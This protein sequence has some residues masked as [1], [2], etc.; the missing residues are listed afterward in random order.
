MK[1]IKSRRSKPSF[2]KKK[3][4]GFV[5]F[6]LIIPIFLIGIYT[7]VMWKSSGEFVSPIPTVLRVKVLGNFIQQKPVELEIEQF[8]KNNRIEYKD[9]NKIADH[10]YKVAFKDGEE[11]LFTDKKSVST[12]V[13]SL[14]LILKR[15]TIDGK[16]FKRLDF[17]YDKPV[18][19]FKES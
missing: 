3:V 12:Q 19:V 15:L 2:K 6:S 16:Q 9:I 14:Q 17:R 18:I 5:L 10:Y 11:I 8:L 7:F 13:S 4:V 1:K